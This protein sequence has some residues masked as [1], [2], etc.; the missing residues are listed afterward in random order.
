M[1]AVSPGPAADPPLDA[2]TA[3]A[4]LYAAHWTGLVRLAWLLLRD[5]SMAEEV[6]QDA[7]VAV[8]GKWS[9]LR[10]TGQAAAYLRRAVVNGCRS[11]QRHR[12]VVDRQLADDIA[13]GRAHGATT[14]RSAEDAALATEAQRTMLATLAGLPRR[15]REV[16]VLRYYGDLSEAEIATALGISTGAVKAHAHRG[17]AAL[18]RHAVA[19][20]SPEDHP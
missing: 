15:Q 4:D 12:R 20:R 17:L 5:Q 8:H 2:D 6:V 18:R 9:G 11:V 7:L 19:S 3:V 10:D 14:V 1:M 13:S 16:L